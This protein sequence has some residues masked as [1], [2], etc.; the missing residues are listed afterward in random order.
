MHH[1][2]L[3]LLNFHYWQGKWWKATLQFNWKKADSLSRWGNIFTSSVMSP[4]W[5]A[6]AKE[7]QAFIEIHH[8]WHTSRALLLYFTI[9]SRLHFGQGWSADWAVK[10]EKIIK[11]K[12]ILQ[13]VFQHVQGHLEHIPFL[14]K[15]CT[16][17][18]GHDGEYCTTHDHLE[19]SIESWVVPQPVLLLQSF[20]DDRQNGHA[21]SCH[22]YTR[23]DHLRDA[24]GSCQL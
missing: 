10:E 13:P 19:R 23:K 24:L 21:R 11:L 12:I 17:C 20:H 22:E 3:H 8:I 9:D 14:I 18:W 15:E 4:F 1:S 7:L 2:A 6:V 16:G 5:S